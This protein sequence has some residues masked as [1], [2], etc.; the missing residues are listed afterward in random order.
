[1]DAGPVIAQ[2]RLS[3]GLDETAEELEPRLAELGV[4]PVVEAIDA[5]ASGRAEPVV[6]DKALASKAPR[7]KKTDGLVDWGRP[8][9]AVKNQVRAMQPW[10][11]A[12]TFWHRADG[13]PLRL[14]VGPVDV[15]E[16]PGANAPPG[17]VVESDGGRLVVAA[18]PGAL[19]LSSL[20]PAGKRLLP[21]A[22]FLRGYALVPGDRL[23][24][25]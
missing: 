24:P 22:E 25:E 11:K 4:D 18:G 1:V 7:I 9:A 20:Q 8:A 14:I 12:Y 2:A 15:V 3:I 17:T 5:L 21:V 23:G 6:Q 19:S 10:P 13:E 16:A